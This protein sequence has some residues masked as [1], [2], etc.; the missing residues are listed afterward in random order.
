[1]QSKALTIAE[2]SKM[3]PNKFMKMAYSSAPS[4]VEMEWGM[5]SPARSVRNMETAQRDPVWV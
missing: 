3:K 4:L 2:C 1:M 5:V